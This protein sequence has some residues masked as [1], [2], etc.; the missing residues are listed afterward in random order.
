MLRQ[1]CSTGGCHHGRYNEPPPP[2]I[3]G[4]PATPDSPTSTAAKAVALVVTAI[5]I[6]DSR[7]WGAARE[8]PK[9]AV[10]RYWT[11][12]VLDTVSK[13]RQTTRG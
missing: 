4:C 10:E 12:G 8:D 3:P 9:R 5:A 11:E 7:S 1:F 13:I 6:V 2:T